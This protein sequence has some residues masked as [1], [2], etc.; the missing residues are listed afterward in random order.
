MKP[1]KP[2]HVVVNGVVVAHHLYFGLLLMIGS[3]GQNPL[4]WIGFLVSLDDV[5]EHTI[6]MDTPLRIFFDRYISPRL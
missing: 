6:T 3:M 4:F 1:P 2:F 5:V